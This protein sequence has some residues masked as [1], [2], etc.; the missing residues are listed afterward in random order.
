MNNASQPTEV[1]VNLTSESRYHRSELITWWD[2]SALLSARV[3]VVGAGALGNEI[4]KNLALVG[5]G[6]LTIV[7]MDIIE[8]TNLARCVFFRSEHEQKFKSE[9]LAFDANRLNSDVKTEFYTC[10]IQ[11][12]GD[13]F[14]GQFDLIVAGLDNREARVWLGAA[15]KRTGRTWIDGAIEGLMGKVQTFV[16]DGPCY[17]CTMGDKDWEALTKRLSC[18]LLGV[19][20]MEGG[21][22]PTNATTSSII[23]GVQAQEAIKYLV[24]KKDYYAIENKVWRMMGEQMATFFSIVEISDDCPFHYDFIETS[25]QAY[26]PEKLSDIWNAFE[27]NSESVLGFYDDFILIEG[28]QACGGQS[29]IGYKDLMKRQGKCKECQA[30]LNIELFSRIQ[31]EETVSSME[32]IPEYWPLKTLIEFN[33]NGKTTRHLLERGKI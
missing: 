10:P 18:K 7:D 22:T 9:V 33:L 5:V 15:A 27:V 17:A 20:E 16:P 3:L 6:N 11:E 2:Q 32:I 8:H 12:L 23:A 21:H 31:H 25:S 19:E 1:E 13:G 28:C 29:K 26:L 30:E 4:V 14:I 24:S